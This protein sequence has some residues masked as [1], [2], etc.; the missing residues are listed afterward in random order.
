MAVACPDGWFLSQI[1]WTGSLLP[2]VPS[3]PTGEFAM[4]DTGTVAF[5][6]DRIS[7]IDCTSPR[8]RPSP[9]TA[10]STCS[11]SGSL[12]VLWTLF[13]KSICALT[14]E[15]GT[16]VSVCFQERSDQYFTYFHILN[17]K[18]ILDT[19]D[20]RMLFRAVGGHQRSSKNTFVPR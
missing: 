18:V 4:L 6:S 14:V 16:S 3:Q 19:S 12:S 11:I 8:L 5:T 7:T 2:L 17:K 20:L 1:I 13:I 9:K 10:L 15:K